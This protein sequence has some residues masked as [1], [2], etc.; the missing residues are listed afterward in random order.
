MSKVRLA[1]LGCGGIMNKHA[2]QAEK[3]TDDVE[4]VGL[5]DV[6]DANMD[7]LIERSLGFM[8][9]PP[10]K[11]ADRE[12]MYTQTKPDAVVIATPHT[13]HYDDACEALGHGCHILM[14][15]PMVTDLEQ[16]YDL[17]DRIAKAGK[18]LC[19]AYNTPC[20]EE[21]YTLRDII[22]NQTY[23]KL[24][25]VSLNLSQNWYQGTKGKWR[26]DPALSGGGQMY[27][28]GAHPL[29]SLIWTVE[30]DVDEVYAQIDKLD[31]Q[32]DI[33]GTATIRFTNGVLA[34]IAI[35]G[36]GPT[37]TQGCWIFERARIEM[38][39]WWAGHFDVTVLP[40][41][42]G[43]ASDKVKYPQMTG[44]NAE[45]L[46]NFIDAILGRDEPRTSPTTGVQ[47]SQL[48]DAIYRSA[49]TGKPAKP[50]LR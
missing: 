2:K 46:D 28:S 48:M 22:R 49:E 21:L 36:E 26:Q 38:N 32:V 40:A 27:D 6:V 15:K 42:G 20:T 7:R 35:S 33:N 23:G 50:M 17:V 8:A 37:G 29:S 18:F 4:I 44:K 41:G 11:F 19:V 31:S 5:C 9:S 13:L 14:E 3:L 30:S 25:V 24:K 1:M 39:P 45:P 12:K 10:P 16:A 34:S 43:F 47:Q